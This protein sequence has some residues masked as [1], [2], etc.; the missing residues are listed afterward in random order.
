MEFHGPLDIESL[1]LFDG[2]NIVDSAR[3]KIVVIFAAARDQ[4]AEGRVFGKRLG[5]RHLHAD[6]PLH[7]LPEL[8]DVSGPVIVVEA[9]ALLCVSFLGQPFS[10]CSS[11]KLSTITSMSSRRSRKGGTTSL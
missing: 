4:G 1:D 2:T 6:G 10:A 7:D 8:A 3:E 5:H 9:L 11:N